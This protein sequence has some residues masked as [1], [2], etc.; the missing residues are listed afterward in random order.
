MQN[1]NE[2]V[3]DKARDQSKGWM[4]TDAETVIFTEG[5]I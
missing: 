3:L 2:T 5:S 1:I 4:T